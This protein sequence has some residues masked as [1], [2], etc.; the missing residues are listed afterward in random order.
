M[1]KFLKKSKEY[2]FWTFLKILLPKKPV[3]IEAGAHDG[4]DTVVMSKKWPAGFIYAFEPVPFL[5]Q[6]LIERT[7]GLQNVK[8]SSFALNDQCGKKKL[9][10]SSGRSD[11]S[12][13]LLKP[14]AHL[15]FHPDVF[16]EQSVTIK[17]TTIE[18]FLKKEN[19]DQV[20]FMWLDIQGMELKVLKASK[21][22]LE[23]VRCIFIEIHF[24]ENYEDCAQYDE[25]KLWLQAQ[26]FGYSFITSKHADAGN[27]LFIKNFW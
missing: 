22:M 12:S 8:V 24:A 13:S 17:T 6:N 20:D 19:I 18:S 4:R 2:F 9:Y 3:I 1:R 5:F 10:L 14:L 7:S 27:V 21:E 26:G 11:A 16:F 23:R 25:I 15:Q